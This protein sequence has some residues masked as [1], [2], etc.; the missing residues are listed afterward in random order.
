[1]VFFL[2]MLSVFVFVN[3]LVFVLFCGGG[4]K[5]CLWI[6]CCFEWR[7]DWSFGVFLG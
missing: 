2:L 5:F 4:L 3:V 6:I 7:N 1:M